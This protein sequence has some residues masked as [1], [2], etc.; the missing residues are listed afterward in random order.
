MNVLITGAA[1]FAGHHLAE[2]LINTTN[3]NLHGIVSFKHR[4]C[5][6]RLIHLD[7]NRLTI[8]YSD[9]KSPVTPRV[10]EAIGPIDAIVN[11]GAESHVDRSIS[12][13]V[14]FVENNV[15]LALNMLEYAKIT[16]PKIFIQISTD[17]VY[18]PAPLNYQHKEWD[19]LIPSNPY[20][21]SK[22]A[23][24]AI[25]IS[26]WR[27]YRVPVVITNTMNLIGERQDTE[28]FVPMTISRVMKGE[29]MPIHGEPGKIGSR[30]YLHARNWADAN[31]F[32]IERGT[33]AMYPDADRPD[34]FH[35]VGEREVDNLEMATM[36]AKAVGKSLRYKL[37]DF[38]STRPGHDL[39]YALD[40]TKLAEEGWK[41]PIPLDESLERTVKWM[42]AH[43]EW[44]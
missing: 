33:P 8:H 22:A 1:G 16:K 9:L 38:H 36:I 41:M 31:K 15:S 32:L 34:R 44:L 12:D 40:G 39:R 7:K 43:T 4:G 23:Q 30:F 37:E 21:A 35:V 5:P 20:S 10:I 14:S 26:Y 25:A 27:T 13:P 42:V 18:G 3:W 11:A 29:V 2:H 19:S 17:E 28:K 6:R 24:E